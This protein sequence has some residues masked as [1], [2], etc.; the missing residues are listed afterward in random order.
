V[1]QLLSLVIAAVVVTP[2]ALLA[3]GDERS[4]GGSPVD[5]SADILNFVVPT[6]L[7]ALGGDIASPLSSGFPGNLG[8]QGSYL[9]LPVLVI[10]ASFAVSRLL[11]RRMVVSLLVLIGVASLASLGPQLRVAGSA[12]GF[13]LPWLP[14]THLPLLEYALPTR[15]SLYVWLPL[16]VVVALWMNTRPRGFKWLVVGAAIL[17][18]VPNVIRPFPPMPGEASVGAWHRAA[19]TPRFFNTGPFNRQQRIL[20]LPYGSG[21]NSML[22][23]ATARMGFTMVGGYVGPTPPSY[24]QSPPG[25]W[26]AGSKNVACVDELARLLRQKRVQLIVVGPSIDKGWVR[27]VHQL[28]GRA[29]VRDGVLLYHVPP[30]GRL[31]RRG[32][33]CRPKESER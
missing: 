19:Y 16:A 14:F 22:W 27:L 5:F 2:F 1:Y 28:A 6:Q 21:G 25:N 8:E 13:P 31:V 20:V 17:C 15:F 18:I 29:S 3:L 33:G 7:T 9:G 12:T 24:L 26:S 23:H 10:L 11:P 4:G 32:N 30:R